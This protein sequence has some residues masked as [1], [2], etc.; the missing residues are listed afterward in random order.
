MYC[1]LNEP[2]TKEVCDLV[3]WAFGFIYTLFF[4]NSTRISIRYGSPIIPCL[5]HVLPSFQVGF[6]SS[7]QR[8]A[9]FSRVVAVTR[10]CLW[11]VHKGLLIFQFP[12]V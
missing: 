5:D 8:G 3:E 12:F 11:W 2:V 10:G 4:F 1:S 6:I 7:S 9:P